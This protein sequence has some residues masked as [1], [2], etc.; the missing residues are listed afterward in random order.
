MIDL[1]IIPESEIINNLDI[2]L[3]KIFT[4]LQFENISMSS[5]KF[6]KYNGINDFIMN[7]L[8]GSVIISNDM[9]T[10]YRLGSIYRK[11]NN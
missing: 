8:D 10:C 9:E 4:D 2:K 1:S 5:Y 7:G 6:E 3:N 11:I